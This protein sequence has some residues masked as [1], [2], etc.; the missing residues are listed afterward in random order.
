MKLIGCSNAGWSFSLTR[1]K[2]VNSM[3]LVL[4]QLDQNK[5]Y[6]YID[7]QNEIEKKCPDVNASKVRMFI[8]FLVKLGVLKNNQGKLSEIITPF[9][10]KFFYFLSLYE[11]IHLLKNEEAIDI[12]EE[13]LSN[14][15]INGYKNLLNDKKDRIY[16]YLIKILFKVEYIEKNEFFLITTVLEKMSDET[17]TV[18]EAEIIKLITE[19]RKGK[20]E[21]I[22]IEENIN[23]FG[24]I[25]PFARSCNL[26]LKKEE[27]YYLNKSRV[28]LLDRG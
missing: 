7:L 2:Q 14:F 27:K 17:E 13:I 16:Y 3:Y 24:Y 9:G 20:I 26:I 5:K 25:M 22:E 6:S 15:L 4:C 23:A 28:N 12:S 21:N 10:K 1:I 18:K 8:P 11:K 19:Y